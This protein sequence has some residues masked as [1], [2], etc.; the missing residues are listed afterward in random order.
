[1]TLVLDGDWDEAQTYAEEVKTFAAGDHRWLSN[2]H[3]IES[4]ICRGRAATCESQS[5][6]RAHIAGALHAAEAAVAEAGK[7]AGGKGRFSRIDALIARGEAHLQLANSPATKLDYGPLQEARRDFLVALEACGTNKKVKQRILGAIDTLT[8]RA[9][10]YLMS[11]RFRTSRPDFGPIQSARRDFEQALKECDA[12]EKVKCACELHLAQVCLACYDVSGAMSHYGRSLSSQS[13]ITNGWL[14][15]LAS[16]V[17]ADI[18][19]MRDFLIPWDLPELDR[20]ELEMSFYLFLAKTARARAGTIQNAADLLDRDINTIKNWLG[21][22]RKLD[23]LR[24]SK[25]V[26]PSADARERRH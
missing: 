3:I 14:T 4:R 16:S 6:A 17:E 24:R 10:V 18:R 8:A 22:E 15:A 9:E 11:D 25:Q 21:F 7:L 26:Q 12:N 20:E 5:D 23:E 13:K 19:K 1:V 2:A